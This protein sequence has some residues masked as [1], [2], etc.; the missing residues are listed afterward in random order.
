MKH[1]SKFMT[2]I[3]GVILAFGLVCFVGC[4]PTQTGP[5]AT[6]VVRS[7]TIQYNGTNVDGVLNAAITQQQIT[8]TA[9]VVKDEG[10]DG[11]VTFA[12]SDE[13]VA[14][15]SA[16]G[17]VTLKTAGETELT[18]TAG[19]KSHSVALVVEEHVTANV[20]E[21]TLT[22]GDGSLTVRDTAGA[23]VTTAKAGTYLMLYP[24]VASDKV[25]AGFEFTDTDSGKKLTDVWVNGN[26]FLMPACNLT[27]SVVYQEA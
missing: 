15:V 25:F 24:N 1:L 4:Q 9:N 5:A 2:L 21:Y 6:P 26:Q 12:S 3:I 8:I 16:S 13:T 11:T 7:V 19:A 23:N 22:V 14:T 10:A 18:A 20:T 27:V 17:I